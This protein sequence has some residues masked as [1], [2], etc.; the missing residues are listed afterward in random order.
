MRQKAPQISRHQLCRQ[1]PY[2]Q[3]K[4]RDCYIM[5]DKSTAGYRIFYSLTQ[6]RGE[7]AKAAD[8]FAIINVSACVRKLNEAFEK[9]NPSD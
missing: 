5:L 3:H 6:L 1:T 2:G 9:T 4:G 7:L 8:I